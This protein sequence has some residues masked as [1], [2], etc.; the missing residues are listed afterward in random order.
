MAVIS[1][2]LQD[3]V[4][5]G[6]DADDTIEGLDGKDKITSGLGND[7]VYGGLGNDAIN[8]GAGNDRLYG[9]DGND[10]L[11]GDAGNDQ[12]FGGL[13]NDG[14]F[15]GGNDDSVFGD[16][17][18]DTLYGDGGNDVID[19]GVGADKIFGGAGD[20]R[21]KG[22]EGNDI[23]AGDAGN[24]T[25]TYASGGGMDTFTG[26]AGSDVVVLDLLSDDITPLFKS[27]LQAY[28]DYQNANATAAGGSMALAGQTTGASFTFASLGLTISTVE[29]LQLRI[30]EVSTPIE[31]LLNTA[32][33]VAA[34]QQLS[35]LEDGVVSGA[36]AAVDAEGD[37]L[38]WSVVTGP[39]SGT[40]SID[41]ATGVFSYAAAANA[42]GNDS[43]DVAVDDGAG[44]VSIQ[45]IRV[46]IDA[47]ADA[48]VL[49]VAGHA[50][51]PAAAILVGTKFAETL[52]GSAGNDTI[53]AGSGDD[54]IHG[55]GAAPMVAPLSIAAGLSDLD[56]S[57]TLSIT[58]GGLVAGMSL[59]AGQDNGDGSWTL[60]AAELAGLSVSSSEQGVFSLSVT[61]TSGE[62]NGSS[63]TSAAT[64][65]VSFGGGADNLRGGKGNDTIHAGFGNDIVR[66]DSGNDTIFGG[67]GDDR[68]SGDSG[69][70]IIHDGAGN[71]IVSGGSGND[72]F[73]AGAGNDSYS[74]GSGFD[75]LDYSG[76]TAALI[77]DASKKSVEGFTADKI[78]GIEKI[79]G[80][81]FADS[82]KGSSGKDNFAAGDG[83]DVL[84]SLG[85]ADVLAGGA[86]DDT[87]QYFK[88]DVLNLTTHLGVD[89]IT[90]FAVGDRL[91]LHD[92]L[93]GSTA[94]IDQLVRVTDSAAGSTISVKMGSAFVDV[95]MLDDVH[96]LT[97][98]SMLAQGMLLT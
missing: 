81:V 59:S 55:D 16:D 33:D 29:T 6:T 73:I 70:D 30:D 45:R 4:I 34:E 42:S 24:D 10:T 91:D 35:V 50:A 47:V 69:D 78:S 67:L 86:G 43:F 77:V 56:G 63:A 44:G 41:E 82:F 52:Q 22:G 48:P 61:A 97:A 23:V 3:D 76:A 17:G 21:L 74:G 80:S 9:E 88:K 66:G 12:I 15:G 26:G 53:S 46:G 2:T 13:G 8:G 36:V 68:L 54:T 83:A 85:G 62:S 89:H 60:T 92:I 64:L 93:K 28:V 19:G 38:T 51:S 98:Q 87:F 75:T 65:D 39:Q 25:Y 90:D 20:D 14:V 49:S 31:S 18:D 27:E 5:A 7:V 79:I 71:D 95:A 84:R 32:P 40:L 72:V 37:A 1:G 11:T 57:E 94:P 58:V 96:G